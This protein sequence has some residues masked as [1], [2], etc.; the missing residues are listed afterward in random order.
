MA[1]IQVTTTIEIFPDKVAAFANDPSGP[2]SLAINAKAQEVLARAKENIGTRYS[3]HHPFPHLRD[4]GRVV[5]SSTGGPDWKVVFQSPGANGQLA[6]LHHNGA[7][8]HTIPLG[9]KGTLYRNGPDVV[10]RQGRTVFGRLMRPP[11]GVSHPGSKP[12]PY[13]TDA[14]AQVG[15]RRSGALLR[16]STLTPIVRTPAGFV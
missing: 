14:A 6:V 4:S 11:H 12:N 16:G 10:D 8:A 9:A 1:S 7:G 15:L 3:G 13:L 5:K 2:G